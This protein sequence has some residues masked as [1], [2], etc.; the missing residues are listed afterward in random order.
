VN[1]IQRVSKQ[2]S[3]PFNRAKQVACKG[4]K[5]PFGPCEKKGWTSRRANP[6]VDSGNFQVGI[7]FN[8]NAPEMAMPLQ[9]GHRTREIFVSHQAF[10]LGDNNAE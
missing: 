2:E 8:I 4:K 5:A 3:N 9:V 7:Q 10:S 1:R 6:S